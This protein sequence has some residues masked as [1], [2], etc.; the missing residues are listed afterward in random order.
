MI[1][2][3]G[4][5]NINEDS[6][7][8]G[9]RFNGQ[10]AVARISQMIE[11][12]AHII[13]VGGVSSRP[14]STAVSK[15]EEM[16]RIKPIIDAIYAHALYEKAQFSLDSYEPECL[17]YAL[18]HGFSLANDITGLSNDDVA[19]VVAKY[20]ASVCIM[21][22]QKDPQTMQDNP[23]YN[24]VVEE[25]ESFF[26]ER[27]AKAKRFGIRDVILDVGIGFGKSLKHNLA[28]I[29]AYDC[30]AKF[31]CEMLIG[32]SRKSMIDHII[33]TP[34][35]ERLP[36]TLVLHVEALRKGASIIRCHDVK[37][38]VQA[39]AVYQALRGEKQ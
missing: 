18:S 33:K 12:G 34:V 25:V 39:V 8:Q 1:K 38:H 5:L 17:E 27:L 15:E 4:V 11:E 32:A 10:A 31:G 36:G 37:E 3:M 21:H 29:H 23:S 2:I 28:L 30:F 16:R 22:M 6:F 26:K 13:D 19:R 9:S 24:N 20:G 14:G 7:F 35:D